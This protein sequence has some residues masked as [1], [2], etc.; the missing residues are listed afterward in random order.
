MEFLFHRVP[1]IRKY[2]ID[3]V[4]FIFAPSPIESRPFTPITDIPLF[5]PKS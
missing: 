1:C 5:I 4:V 2:E 3:E